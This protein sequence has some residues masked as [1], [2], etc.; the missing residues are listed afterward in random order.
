LSLL[1]VGV[2]DGYWTDGVLENIS[3]VGSTLICVRDEEAVLYER[4]WILG[5]DTGTGLDIHDDDE[6]DG[7][8][9][10]ERNEG[11]G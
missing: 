8:N 5:W 9:G 10:T 11:V 3:G 7:W 4:D 2:R 1:R 6:M